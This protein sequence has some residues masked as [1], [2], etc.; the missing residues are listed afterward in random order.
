MQRVVDRAAEIESR[1]REEQRGAIKGK[2]GELVAGVS[3]SAPE[4]KETRA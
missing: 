2:D 4:R 3:G 1:E